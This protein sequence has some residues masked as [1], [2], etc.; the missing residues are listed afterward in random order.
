MCPPDR[1]W[2]NGTPFCLP[3]L[4]H[5]QTPCREDPHVQERVGGR[6]EAG[7]RPLRGRLGLHLVVRA[8]RRASN[9]QAP[10]VER[11]G[12]FM[13]VTSVPTLRASRAGRG[14]VSCARTDGA[15]QPQ[16]VLVLG[17]RLRPGLKPT[18]PERPGIP[19]K[20]DRDEMVEFIV[21][22]GPWEALCEPTL[23]IVASV[24][25][26]STSPGTCARWCSW[27]VAGSRT[28]P[29]LTTTASSAAT[30]PGS[31]RACMCF[32]PILV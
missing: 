14:R 9:E 27:P 3:R 10:G 21:G 8:P 23:R 28:G 6:A 12:S 16:L 29:T 31:A 15:G 26:P 17:R 24:T 1:S 4:L 19:S 7:D 25:R 11:M 5:S 2:R 18:V 22:R 32:S 30:A 13:P 20:P